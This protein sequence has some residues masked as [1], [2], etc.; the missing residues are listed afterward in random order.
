ME[1]SWVALIQFE[2][3]Y[4]IFNIIL[5]YTKIFISI[6][7]SKEDNTFSLTQYIQGSFYI[8]IYTLKYVPSEIIDMDVFINCR[9]KMTLVLQL[10][11][12]YLRARTSYAMS[13]KTYL[14]QDMCAY[15][16]IYHHKKIFQR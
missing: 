1:I 4:A 10:A 16:D 3:R 7:A 2:W 14:C 11:T 15:K 6:L 5:V 12:S 9:Y 8:Y 13:K